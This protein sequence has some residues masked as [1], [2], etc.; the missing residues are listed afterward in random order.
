MHAFHC[1]ANDRSLHNE[2]W[3]SREYMRQLFM[4]IAELA[5]RHNPEVMIKKLFAWTENQRGLI[6]VLSPLELDDDLH[7]NCWKT[8]A[9][10]GPLPP[11]VAHPQRTLYKKSQMQLQIHRHSQDPFPNV[12]TLL[13]G[14]QRGILAHGLNSLSW[15]ESGLRSKFGEHQW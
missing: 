3:S 15:K 1:P 2:L 14:I 10:D 6:E 8:S 13:Y 7:V 4:S 12:H 5:H 9:I 11:L